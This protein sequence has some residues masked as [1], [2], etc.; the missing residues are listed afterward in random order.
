MASAT[1]RRRS[2]V[3][4]WPAVPMAANAMARN[5]RSRSA[6]GATMA[7]LL[8]PS[9]RMPRANRAARRGPTARA[10]AGGPG[11]LTPATPAAV[12]QHLADITPADQD[13][14]QTRW[15]IAKPA[16][17]ALYDSLCRHGG[18]RRL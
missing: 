11:A 18:E 2:V 17:G 15:R 8:P 6:D 16:H 4:R 7:A 3:Q 14:R 9:S 13:F 10:I 1:N 5:A 12:A